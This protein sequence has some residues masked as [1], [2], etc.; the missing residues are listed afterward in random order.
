[1]AALV[2][3]RWLKEAERLLLLLAKANRQGLTHDWEFTEWLHGESGH[4]MGF[5][6][7]GWSAA[8]FLYADHTV[9][10]GQLPLFDD[11]LAVKPASAIATEVN[12]VI[13]RPGGGP[14]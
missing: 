6:Q 8:M 3:H 7:Q 4:P 5:T 13:I 10:T 9:R 14:V 1:V 11:L 2:R 12:D